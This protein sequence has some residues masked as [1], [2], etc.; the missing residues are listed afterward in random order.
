[1]VVSK[2]KSC[3]FYASDYHFEMIILPY[4]N[5]KLQ[6]DKNIYVFTQ[7]NLE[8]TINVL[9]EKVNLKNEVKENI[10]KINWKD[11]DNNKYDKL[12]NDNKQK[13]VFVKGNEEYIEKINNNL[14]QIEENNKLEIIDCY[15]VD[16]VGNKMMN[17]SK[18]YK[19]VMITSKI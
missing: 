3:A 6:E 7:N 17:I 18:K 8:E 1:M 11:E 14:K 4:I 12:I 19:K 2:E 10:L 13:I 9:V 15:N 16:E 5:K